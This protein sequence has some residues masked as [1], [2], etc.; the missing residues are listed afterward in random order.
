MPEE[1]RP[2]FSGES[3]KVG[4]AERVAP[5]NPPQS[6]RASPWIFNTVN[7]FNFSR[8]IL[9]IAVAVLIISGAI[10]SSVPR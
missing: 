5:I 4:A 8:R 1:E 6:F 10:G 9:A 2:L 7:A 3:D